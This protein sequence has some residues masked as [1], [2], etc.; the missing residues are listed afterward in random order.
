MIGR[1]APLQRRYFVRAW[2]ESGILADSARKQDQGSSNWILQPKGG[3]GAKARVT[4]APV[5]PTMETGASDS[6][7]TVAA[8]MPTDGVNGVALDVED[9]RAHG[10]DERVPVDSFDR[11]LEFHYRLLKLLTTPQVR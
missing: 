10:R 11:G 3:R 5:I 9:F 6:V 2:I 7:Y 1:P 4:G 8:R